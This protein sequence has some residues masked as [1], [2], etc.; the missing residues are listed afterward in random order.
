MFKNNSKD[1]SEAVQ[2]SEPHCFA[3]SEYADL[4][5]AK[6]ILSMAYGN[7]EGPVRKTMP[8]N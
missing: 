8:C 5:K 4:W 7:L 6:L 2:Q 3:A 1:L